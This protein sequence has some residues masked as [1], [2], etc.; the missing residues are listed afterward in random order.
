M[1]ETCAK[2]LEA[3]KDYWSAAPEARTIVYRWLEEHVEACDACAIAL[4]D[5]AEAL[6]D[7]RR[8]A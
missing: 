1:N 5:I 7:S 4:Q 8:E 3:A 2:I 6:L